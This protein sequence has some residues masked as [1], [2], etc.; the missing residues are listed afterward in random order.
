VQ[1]RADLNLLIPARQLMEADETLIES[2]ARPDNVV[3]NNRIV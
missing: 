3:V 2:L 1:H